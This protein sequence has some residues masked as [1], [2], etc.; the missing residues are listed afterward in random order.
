MTQRHTVFKIS[1]GIHTFDSAH[2]VSG[3]LQVQLDRVSVGSYLLATC[4]GKIA[5]VLQ[6]WCDGLRQ[7]KA[8]YRYRR[9]EKQFDRG[10]RRLGQS[11][12]AYTVILARANFKSLPSN[13]SLAIVDG[14]RITNRQAKAWY[15]QGSGGRGSGSRLA[16]SV[17]PT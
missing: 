15:R 1:P 7:A 10:P 16:S 3:A 13:Q 6:Q 4:A 5:K 2:G 14:L 12:A 8:W 9:S 11:K 17:G